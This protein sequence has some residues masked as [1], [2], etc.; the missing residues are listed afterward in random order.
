M[1]EAYKRKSIHFGYDEKSDPVEIPLFHTFLVGITGCGKTTGIKS[2]LK[3]FHDKYPEWKILIIDSKDKRDYS[4]LGSDIN[5]VFSEID[6]PLDLKNLFEPLVG[7]SMFHF[8][9][10]IIEQLENTT[11][12]GMIEK[13]HR[14]DIEN[15]VSKN[16]SQNEE[17][18]LRVIGYLGGK[19]R[20]MIEASQFSNTLRL[21]SGFNVMPIRI[22]GEISP[23]MKTAMKQLVVRSVIRKV[24]EDPKLEQTL[25]VIDE[26]HR[27]IPQRWSGI[28]KQAVS[29]LIS[30][31]RSQDKILWLADQALT[32]IDKEPLKNIRVFCIG[33]QMEL[34]EVKD[35]VET[36]SD[37]TDQIIKA[38]QV[39]SLL[40]GFF[41]VVDGINQ[42]VT[43]GYL[44][45]YGVPD[46]VAKNIASGGSPEIAEPYITS[47]LAHLATS[48]GIHIPIAKE[49]S[50][51]ERLKA[52]HAEVI[53]RMLRV[54]ILRGLDFDKMLGVE[55]QL[56]ENM[57]F[58]AMSAPIEYTVKEIELKTYFYR[59]QL[60]TRRFLLAKDSKSG[61][62]KVFNYPLPT[63]KRLE[64]ITPLATFSTEFLED[65]ALV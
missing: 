47:K 25:I 54:L 64:E 61:S 28:C 40:T 6:D 53:A 23:N 17:G 46:E 33:Q 34:N 43:K 62:I 27:Y 11:L 29:E 59:L 57:I 4:D 42:K 2:L 44:Q 37:F 56:D 58:E 32:R 3:R 39:K 35:A 13:I 31:G 50:E 12:E 30:E 63:G 20:D 48:G 1:S 49:I 38:Q 9:D 8:L 14:L 65:Q 21:K 51:G 41:Y 26:A 10:T 22:E 16:L 19:I 36:A 18:K 52:E 24:L 55:K 7:N 45:P 5:P 60:G 15:V